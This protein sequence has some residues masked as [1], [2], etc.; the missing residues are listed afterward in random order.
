MQ[1]NKIESFDELAANN[2]DPV[3]SSSGLDITV[4]AGTF[5]H[6]GTT[7][8]LPSD[9]T[10]AVTPDGANTLWLSLYLAIEI[11][12]GDVVVFLDEILEDGVDIPYD[13]DASATH[14]RICQLAS[15]QVA[16]AA[17]DLDDAPADVWAVVEPPEE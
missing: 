7:Y 12:S 16:A 13:W 8:V 4:E 9:F 2:I 15:I 11:S 3:L 14:T 5:V 10:A 17:A 1:I 6:A